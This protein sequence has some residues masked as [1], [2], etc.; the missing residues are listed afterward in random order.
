MAPSNAKSFTYCYYCCHS[1]V[2]TVGVTAYNIIIPVSGIFTLTGTFIL[3]NDY[4]TLITAAAATYS[5]AF[6]AYLA[7]SVIGGNAATNGD[8]SD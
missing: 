1:T 5:I 3:T 8:V 4:S 2:P 7:T 6:T